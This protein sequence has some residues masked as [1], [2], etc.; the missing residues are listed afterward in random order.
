MPLPI[1]RDYEMER[2]ETNDSSSDNNSPDVSF[3]EQDPIQ[4]TPVSLPIRNAKFSENQM[5]KGLSEAIDVTKCN[6]WRL[7]K[8]LTAFVNVGRL[9]K[10]H[11][12]YTNDERTF[13]SWKVHPKYK[14]WCQG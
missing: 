5:F 11:D 7:V 3:T 2:A 14:A 9:E 6:S 4:E 1:E 8:A 13:Y 10:P 12:G